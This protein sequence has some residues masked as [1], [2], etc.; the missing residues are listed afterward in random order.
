MPVNRLSSTDPGI[1]ENMHL[2]SGKLW[3]NFGIQAKFY[4]VLFA[5]HGG[6]LAA[7][8]YTDPLLKVTFQVLVVSISPIFP[9]FSILYQI[10]N[11][12][13]I[14]IMRAVANASRQNYLVGPWR[15]WPACSKIWRRTN[16]NVVK[17]KSVLRSTPCAQLTNAENNA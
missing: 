16:G 10:W 3:R 14:I 12:R 2:K 9:I 15:W 5:N 6:P 4:Q 17:K 11:E 13:G 8:S 7:P 1:G